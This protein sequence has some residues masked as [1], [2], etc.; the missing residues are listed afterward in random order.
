[1]GQASTPVLVWL[2]LGLGWRHILERWLPWFPTIECRGLI[3]SA[4]GP[5]EPD[6]LNPET[7][8]PK[9]V[10]TCS[11]R[12]FHP[13]T[14]PRISTATWC[15]DARQGLRFARSVLESAAAVRSSRPQQ[16]VSVSAVLTA[17]GFAPPV[18][19]WR[20]PFPCRPRARSD[21]TR[22][23]PGFSCGG[24]ALGPIAA[25][26]RAEALEMGLERA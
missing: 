10:A 25:G 23:R 4:Y 24:L 11:R 15:C 19:P 9:G 3:A 12:S 6:E 22:N 13:P 18:P 7:W 2:G 5:P 16:G 26:A 1:M 14:A 8:W 17:D 20:E 21:W